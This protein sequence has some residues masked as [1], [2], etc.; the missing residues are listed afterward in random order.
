M[1]FFSVLLFVS[2]LSGCDLLG[3]KIIKTD[4]I[5]DDSQRAFWLDDRRFLYARWEDRS[6]QINYR[7]HPRTLVLY[8]IYTQKEAILKTGIRRFCVVEDKILYYGEHKKKFYADIKNVGGAIKLQTVEEGEYNFRCSP[9]FNR[10]R[11]V[12]D[13][14]FSYYLP[15]FDATISPAV[16]RKAGPPPVMLYVK[17]DEKKRLPF[18][19]GEALDVVF[20]HMNDRY[21]INLNYMPDRSN[22]FT[23][24]PWPEEVERTAWWLYR[25]GQTELFVWPKAQKRYG[26]VKWMRGGMLAIDGRQMSLWHGRRERVLWYGRAYNTSVSPNGCLVAFVHKQK[27]GKKNGLSIVKACKGED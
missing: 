7:Y 13:D 10:V 26:S 4:F 6:G 8:D 14:V 16:S 5:G 21:F 18:Y 1:R 20:D 12:G 9:Q 24:F 2:F 22:R 19:Y 27:F 25:D 11:Q 23:A 3:P 15:A 17:G